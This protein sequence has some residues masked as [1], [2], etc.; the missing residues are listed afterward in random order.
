MNRKQ[1]RD[2]AKKIASLEKNK[3]DYLEKEELI[4]N[5]ISQCSIQ[6]LLEIDDIIMN[7]YLTNN[8]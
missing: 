7:K 6:D 8:F 2:T 3:K 5:L 1:R 4:E